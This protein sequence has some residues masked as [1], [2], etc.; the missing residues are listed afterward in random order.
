MLCD[1]AFLSPPMSRP[2]R[3]GCALIVTIRRTNKKPR[4]S[5]RQTRLLC[6][7]SNSDCVVLDPLEQSEVLLMR[8]ELVCRIDTDAVLE[9]ARQIERQFCLVCGNRSFRLREYERL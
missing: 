1:D 2:L 4:P 5:D 6:C 8:Q 7:V 3:T 9:D